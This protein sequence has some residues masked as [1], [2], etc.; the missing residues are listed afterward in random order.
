[1]A[2]HEQWSS[3]HCAHEHGRLS[4]MQANSGVPG[5]TAGTTCSSSTTHNMQNK[6]TIL[7]NIALVHLVVSGSWQ[8][9]QQEAGSAGKL[10]GVPSD[11]AAATDDWHAMLCKP[12]EEWP[13]VNCICCGLSEEC[14]GSGV[15]I[16][17]LHVLLIFV[18]ACHVTI[19]VLLH[20][21]QDLTVATSQI[22]D[23]F[24]RI[25]AI[26]GKA[27]DSEALVQDICRDICKVYI[28]CPC[29]QRNR[30]SIVRTALLCSGLYCQNFCC[31]LATQL[32]SRAPQSA[33]TTMHCY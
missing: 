16:T 13:P 21:R 15:M 9:L 27:A 14:N 26:Q 6:T 24:S 8:A 33:A 22:G 30:L 28:L 31:Q 12:Q 3:I 7:T 4:S 29:T 23:L 11:S 2:I 32:H 20:C 5:T 10:Q 25:R 18:T 1:M 19:A 17:V